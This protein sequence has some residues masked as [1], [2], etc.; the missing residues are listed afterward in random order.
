MYLYSG[1]A[2]LVPPTRFSASKHKL[3]YRIIPVT[4]HRLLLLCCILSLFAACGGG[5]EPLPTEPPAPVKP[6]ISEPDPDPDPELPPSTKIDSILAV[7]NPMPEAKLLYDELRAVYGK[8][9]LSGMMAN[10]NW[11]NTESERVH[12]LTGRFPTINSYD[13]IHLP[14]SP[15]NW[16]DYSDITPALNWHERGGI[17]AAGWHWLVPKYEGADT[18]VNAGNMVYDLSTSFR[19]ANVPVTG[20][21][22]NKVAI[23]DLDRL[24]TYLMLLRD[25]GIPVL[26]RPLHEA[27]G[28]LYEYSSGEAWFWWGRDGAEAYR[29]LWR[30]M[31][32][33]FESCGLNNLIWI[34]TTQTKDA[35]FYPGDD[36]VDIIGRDLYGNS[37]TD[38]A[39]QYDAV[40]KAYPQKMAALTECGWS[41]YTNSRVG[42]I[43]AQWTA[44]AR[45]LWFMPW[46]DNTGATQRHADDIWWID[47]MKQEYVK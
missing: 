23:A 32:D 36:Y 25:A 35:A 21:W 24:A 11:N 20:T 47:A 3:M 19:P 33:Y 1:A 42:L 9:M 17:I 7:S 38:C 45:W 44:G 10:V 39:A 2:A 46:Y 34:W 26:W 28:N 14:F 31:F 30:F 13:Y 27:A 40:T 41:D 18:D 12:R 43:S 8:Q 16:I 37:A 29:A 22:E 5:E 6:P 4:L 15:S